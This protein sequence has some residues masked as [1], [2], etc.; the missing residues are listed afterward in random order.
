MTQGASPEGRRNGTHPA[1]DWYV[2]VGC[3]PDLVCVCVCV[4]V[5]VRACVCVCVD[6]FE[7]LK[8]VQTP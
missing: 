3:G 2:P 8:H 5:C 6:V 4:C 1:V 7:L